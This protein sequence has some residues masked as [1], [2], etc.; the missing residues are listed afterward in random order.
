[1]YT[2]R[3]VGLTRSLVLTNKPKRVLVDAHRTSGSLRSQICD[4]TTQKSAFRY[5]SRLDAGYVYGSRLYD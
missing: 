5:L 3:K 2:E 4:S 1:M